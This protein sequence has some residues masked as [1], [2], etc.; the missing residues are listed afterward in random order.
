MISGCRE[1]EEVG[2][3]SLLSEG[4]PKNAVKLEMLM[5]VWYVSK[6]RHPGLKVA[7]LYSLCVHLEARGV[8]P[9]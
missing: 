1:R 5:A 7:G 9:Q 2:S 3:N 6:L 8:A 4:L